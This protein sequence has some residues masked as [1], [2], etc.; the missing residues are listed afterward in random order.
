M[1]YSLTPMQRDTLLVIQELTALDG[2]PPSLR[3]IARELDIA[4]QSGV[5]RA[6]LGLKERGWIDWRPGQSRGIVVLHAPPAPAECDIAV[7]PYG[8][9]AL[10][11]IADAAEARRS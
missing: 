5:H 6:L 11:A 10:A 2:R 7:T 4:A 3:E 1:T 9:A 8:R